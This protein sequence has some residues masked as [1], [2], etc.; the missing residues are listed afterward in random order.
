MCIEYQMDSCW[1][2]NRILTYILLGKQ[3]NPFPIAIFSVPFR[4]GKQKKTDHNFRARSEAFIK[5]HK[6]IHKWY[7]AR[8]CAHQEAVPYHY[9]KWIF[10]E[11]KPN[12]SERKQR[13]LCVC[14][15]FHADAFPM[16]LLKIINAFQFYVGCVLDA[17][18]NS[19][20]SQFVL[21]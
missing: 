2:Y 8:T 4:N 20:G 1:W 3:T 6:Q 5:H 9:A 13:N 19:Y 17:R 21:Q 11:E 12:S 18:F 14:P 10:V 16:L 15:R 7:E